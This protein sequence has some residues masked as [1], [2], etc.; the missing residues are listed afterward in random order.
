M[1]IGI[2]G[3][4]ESGK[5]TVAKMIQYYF[6]CKNHKISFS[7]NECINGVSDNNKDKVPFNL[8]SYIQERSN[9][10]IKKFAWKLKQVCAL[11]VGCNP[12]D[13]ENEDFKNKLLPSEFQPSTSE[14]FKPITYR[15][16]L[17]VVGTEA[18]RNNVHTN[19]WV[20]ALM[21]DYK[22]LNPE[23]ASSALTHL[24]Y[25]DCDFPNWIITDVRFPNELES[26]KKRDGLIFRI[27][28][29]NLDLTKSKYQHESEKHFH[30]FD[31]DALF[32]NN[33]SIDALYNQVNE[34][35]PK[36]L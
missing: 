2:I 9:I 6:A 22:A 4:S 36:L 21:S 7:L 1:I 35:I 20:N 13:F 28:R 14:A 23:K 3:Y 8:H 30:N 29:S 24:D 5:D 11:L 25:R 33:S 34:I 26:I 31:Y 18:M 32:E 12:E 17:Q 19:V 27:N 10:K 16:L 15:I